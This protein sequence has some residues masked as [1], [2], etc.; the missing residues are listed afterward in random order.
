[1]LDFFSE[2]VHEWFIPSARNFLDI[3]PSI[4]LSCPSIRLL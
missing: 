4:R 1:M 2:H 3:V